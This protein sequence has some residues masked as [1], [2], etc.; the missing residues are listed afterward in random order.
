MHQIRTTATTPL[1]APPRRAGVEPRVAATTTP[2]PRA[3]KRLMLA[4][5]SRGPTAVDETTG[6]LYV[7]RYRE[8]ERLLHEPRMHGVGLSLFDAMGITHGALRD[9]YGALMFTNDGVSHDRLRRLV[10]KAFTPRAAARLRP[11][12]AAHVA[13]RLSLLRREAGG[14]LVPALAHVPMHVM[15]ALIGVSAAA[16]PE[17]ITWVDALSPIFGFMEPAQIEAAESA[18]THL[19]DYVRDLVAERS[20]TPADDLLSALLR[21]EHDGDRLTRDETVAM[22]ANLLVGGHDTTGSQI[23]CTLLTLLARPDSLAALRTDPALLPL[24]VSETLRFEPS[25]SLAMRTVVEPIEICGVERPAG[26]IVMCTFLT[27][28][29]DPEVWRDPDAFVPR[30][31]AEL[32]V[33]RLFSFGGGPHYCLGAALARMTLEESVR[34]VAALAPTLTVDPESIEWCRVLGQSPARLPVRI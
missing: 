2:D 12:A 30:R 33:P 28:N 29:R 6:V 23:G 19:L 18:I 4:A 27:A 24:L 16:V 8:V 32:D 31:F 11:T 17:F 25:I 9:W 20:A 5:A 34:G 22:V 15:C 10:S 13:E 1:V 7:L 21:A 14:D 3:W 26:T